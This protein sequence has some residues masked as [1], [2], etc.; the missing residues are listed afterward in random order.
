MSKI[1]KAKVIRK[2]PTGLPYLTLRQALALIK[3]ELGLRVSAADITDEESGY[4]FEIKLGN[5]YKIMVDNDVIHL[6]GC[7][8]LTI[9][10]NYGGD[11]YIK[12]Y[13]NPVT[14]EENFEVAEKIR[15]KERQEDFED[16]LC[17]IGLEG[18]KAI[19]AQR[20]EH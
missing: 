8:R 17:E 19:L 7:F 2:T 14:L 13:F 15:A 3:K 20:G 16:S 12:K 9:Q 10:T 1:T 11:G 18:C 5:N 4:Y 6:T